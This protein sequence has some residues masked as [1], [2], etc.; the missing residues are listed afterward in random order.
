MTAALTRDLARFVASLRYEQLPPE[1]VAMAK[2]GFIDSTATLLAGRDEPCVAVLQRTLD[3]AP[4]DAALFWGDV[5]VRAPEA[6][7][8]NAVAS[9][10]LDYDD[11]ALS[12]HP[13]AVMVPAI[14]AEAQHLGLSGRDMLCAYAA[15]FEVWAELQRRDA[16]QHHTKG[17][18]P[19]GVFGSVAAAAACASLRRSSVEQTAMALALG[20]SQSAG[21][22]A[23]FGSMAKPFHAGRAAHAGVLAARLAAEGMTGAPDALEHSH[24][25]LTAIS[26]SG[27]IER[28]AP[29]DAGQTWRLLS[30]G[31][32]IKKY[33]VCYC[34]HRPIDAMLD[35]R[36]AHPGLAA[37][38]V[39]KITVSMSRRNA[40]VLRNAQPMTGLEAKFSIQFAMACALTE[41]R[42]GL[43]E[44]DDVFVRRPVI[45]DLMARVQVEF[46]PREDPSTGYAPFDQVTLN[47]RNGDVLRSAQVSKA[48]GAASL[49]L[50]EE[51]IRGKFLDCATRSFEPPAATALYDRLQG[52]ERISNISSR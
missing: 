21:I 48:R 19:T 15:G 47:H 27:V 28:D 43:R 32:S 49:P 35:L 39:E 25:F 8:I 34:A 9:H 16:G 33:P 26:P 42:V 52:L 31:L 7:W 22:T 12:A 41:G 45:Q 50:T 18:H 3:P 36:A 38:N 2:L 6:A 29:V 40:D 17:W 14:V 37:E 51:E 23:N 10:A 13:S 46:D 4:G 30:I 1:A 44:L 11:V 24:G 20:A 5:R